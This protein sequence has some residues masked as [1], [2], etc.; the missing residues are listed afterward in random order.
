MPPGAGAACPSSPT[1]SGRRS[2]RW[3]A[4]AHER[5]GRPPPGHPTPSPFLPPAPAPAGDRTPGAIQLSAIFSCPLPWRDREEGLKSPLPFGQ[6]AGGLVMSPGPRALGAGPAEAGP[7]AQDRPPAAGTNRPYMSGRFAVPVA[8][9][10]AHQD[11]GPHA[12]PGLVP[13]PGLVIMYHWFFFLLPLLVWAQRL[14]GGGELFLWVRAGSLLADSQPR[15]GLTPLSP[16]WLLRRGDSIV[17]PA[18]GAPLL[19]PGR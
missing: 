6:T 11:G 9:E 5:G 3:E 1:C 15:A 19:A 7:P 13:G 4:A 12:G 18:P 8:E 16:A 17:A 14:P 2:S 10:P